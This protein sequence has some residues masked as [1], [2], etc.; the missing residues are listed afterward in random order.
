MFLILVCSLQFTVG[1]RDWFIGWFECWV[2]GF[3]SFDWLISWDT[4]TLNGKYGSYGNYGN[5]S[6]C[7][8]S[9]SMNLPS[10]IIRREVGCFIISTG[11]IFQLNL[12]HWLLTGEV[13]SVQ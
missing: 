7:S 9:A 5:D 1:S 6:D 4:E 12:L 3:G 8:L 2:D 13:D 10:I 11:G